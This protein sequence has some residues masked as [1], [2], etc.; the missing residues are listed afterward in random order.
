[1]TDCRRCDTKYDEVAVGFYCPTCQSC[2]E[3][4]CCPCNRLGCDWCSDV[5]F[6][7]LITLSW[8][9][10]VAIAHQPQFDTREEVLA[11]ITKMWP[12]YTLAQF[13]MEIS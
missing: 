9:N 13:Q 8:S 3:C 2:Q 7:T 12:A 4:G 10:G 6:D 5:E 1:M 11:Y